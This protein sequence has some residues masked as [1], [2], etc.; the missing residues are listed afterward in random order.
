[1]DALQMMPHAD[2]Q[3]VVERVVAAARAVHDVMI[4]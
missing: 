3:P 4:V 2:R 1:M